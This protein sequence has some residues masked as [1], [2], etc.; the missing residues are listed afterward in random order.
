MEASRKRSIARRMFLQ[1]STATVAL[2]LLGA[3]APAAAPSPTAAPKAAEPTK[4]PAQVPPAST[5]APVATAA[6]SATQAPAAAT[7]AAGPKKGGTFTL[8]RTMAMTKFNPLQTMMGHYAFMR[9]L[10][11]TLVSY[12]QNLQP[13]AE[14]ATKWDI[15]AD[16]KT[17]TL[18]LR[19]GVKFHNGREFTSADVKN[20]WEW[21]TTFEEVTMRSMFKTI[22]GVDTPDKYT[23]VLKFDGIYPGVFDLLGMM[24]IVDK[25]ALGDLAKTANGTGPFKLDKYLPNDRIELVPFADHWDKGK[26]YLDRYVI[27][28]IPDLASLA[29]N[30]ESGAVDAIWQPNNMD[31]M[32]LKNA[33][34]LVCDLGA[35]GPTLYDVALNVTVKPLDNKQVRQAI[36]W[37]IDRVR[38]CRTILQGMVEPTCLMWASH[39]W[40]YQK[41]LEGKIGFDLDRAKALLKEGGYPDGF[42]L[43][44][45]TSSKRGLGY[46]DITQIM[47]ADLKKIGVNIKIVD[48]E[49]AQYEAR[50]T[51]GNIVAAI[52]SYGRANRDPGTLVTGAKAWTN[53]KEGNWTHWENAQWDQ[54]RTE[55]NSTLDQ[56]KR[57]AT[58]RKL[59]EMA[60]D[61]CF[62]IVI[63]PQQRTWVYQPYVK[64][65]GYDLENTPLMGDV[66]LEK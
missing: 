26:P 52:H 4:P 66:W 48:L 14:L 20:T 37:S 7:K 13:Q 55:L 39:S 31:Y 8:A 58:A 57:K 34:K 44:L 50:M 9:A 36:A 5:A 47:Q 64:G 12:D 29:I 3:C 15:S 32:R 42:E 40:A 25:D 6:P 65:F 30:V 51:P 62:T 56:E 16:G 17:V 49:I 41:D 2:G 21:A 35:P 24:Y 11:N 28:D 18:K 43:E 27:R 59:Q 53:F 10:Y 54:L 45:M 1:L 38:F 60:L 23:A 46:G 63:A 19:E 61:E 33:S 22:K